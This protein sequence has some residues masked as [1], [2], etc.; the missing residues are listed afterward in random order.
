MLEREELKSQIDL[1]KD[2]QA[3]ISDLGPT[4]DC[5]VFFDGQYWK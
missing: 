3:K 1:L 5:I 2:A 4:F